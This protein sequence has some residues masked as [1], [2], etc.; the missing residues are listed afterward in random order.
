MMISN[1]NA[2]GL[3]LYLQYKGGIISLSLNIFIK[4]TSLSRTGAVDPNTR[5]MSFSCSSSL[6][7]PAYG[8]HFRIKFACPN[9]IF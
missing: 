5:M 3:M 6:S 7:T 2:Y 8:E 1:E 4:H 9:G